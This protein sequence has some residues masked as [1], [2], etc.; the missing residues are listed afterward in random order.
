M[1]DNLSLHN[2]VDYDNEILKTI[3]YYNLFHNETL[4]LINIIKPHVKVW[5][6]TGCGTGNLIEK[7]L[8]KFPD[9]KFYLSD[10][11]KSM[12][13]ICNDKFQGKPIEILGEYETAQIEIKIQPEIITAIQCHHYLDFKSR[14][15]TTNH[16]FNLLSD[17]GIYI[18]FENIKPESAEGIEIG[19]KRWNDYQRKQGKNEN[20]IKTHL[21]RFDNHFYPIK[22]NEHIDIMKKAGFKTVELFWMSNMQAGFYGIR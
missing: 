14:I 10:P 12:L 8:I 5:L 1:I 6:D 17:G 3:T 7:A 9:C 15:A 16:C 4:S 19:L 20:D 11:S 22:I 21:N 2:A 18:T 13:Q